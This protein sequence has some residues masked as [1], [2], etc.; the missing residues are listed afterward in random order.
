MMIYLTLFFTTAS[1]GFS[2]V[3]PTLLQ[4][5]PSAVVLSLMYHNS[6]LLSG[7]VHSKKQMKEGCVMGFRVY[8]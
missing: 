4:V 8:S 1:G 6:A 7:C 5:P 3:L 2:E